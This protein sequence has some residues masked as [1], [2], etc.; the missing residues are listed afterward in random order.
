LPTR[1]FGFDR[2]DGGFTRNKSFEKGEYIHEYLSTFPVAGA[3]IGA[4]FKDRLV[5]SMRYTDWQEITI[6]DSPWVG[7]ELVF[8]LDMDEYDPIRTCGCVG[9]E[10]CEICWKLMQVAA[11]I[12]DDTLREDFG[13][14]KIEW[15]YT[16]GRG[17]HAWVL[18]A[19]TFSLDKEQRE[20]IVEYMKIIKKKPKKPDPGEIVED[21]LIE[22]I[23]DLTDDARALKERIYKK[24]GRDYILNEKNVRLIEEAGFTQ[25]T[26]KRARERLEHSELIRDIVDS[27][28]N[29]KK[30]LESAIVRHYPRIDYKVTIDIKRLIRMPGSVHIGTK[31]IS[32]FIEDPTTFNPLRD[33]TNLYDVVGE[34][35]E[36][37]HVT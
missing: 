5:P 6:H 10:V 24:I 3:Y 17:Y 34:P 37:E 27:V 31:N 11:D 16:G 13:F 19:P 15:V 8:D 22:T 2:L 7:R 20:A 9:R 26:L 25:T 30:F 28:P 14:K 35:G 33:A 23:E 18:D 21:E 12:I 32:Q 29:E 4:L 1:E 36:F